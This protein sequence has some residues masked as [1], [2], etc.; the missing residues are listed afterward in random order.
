MTMTDAHIAVT[1][2]SLY[3]RAGGRQAACAMQMLQRIADDGSHLL[4][5]GAFPADFEALVLAVLAREDYPESGELH[6][7]LLELA[8]EAGFRR[9]AAVL[10][11]DGPALSDAEACQCMVVAIRSG[12]PALAAVLLEAGVSPHCRDEAGTPLLSHAIGARQAG[13]MQLLK[14]AGARPDEE[15][16]ALATAA[17][18]GRADLVCEC[19]AYG[20]AQA[21]LDAAL[22]AATAA[23]Q[24]EAMAVLLDA[25]ASAGAALRQAVLSGDADQAGLIRAALAAQ[26]Q[27]RH[28]PSLEDLAAAA[29]A[30][31]PPRTALK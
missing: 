3:W 18:A 23:G 5:K 14:A 6:L 24:H 13:I 8:C 27:G 28:T 22:A 26:L 11:R 20:P 7:D 15:G 16:C 9:L 1:L 10:L 30:L 25:G 17:V 12:Q 21:A 2:H 31:A 19:L 4:G 29:R